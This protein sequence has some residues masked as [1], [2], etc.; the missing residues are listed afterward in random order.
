[1][2]PGCGQRAIGSWAWNLSARWPPDARKAGHL[3]PGQA[4]VR[5]P[6][7]GV[8]PVD[9]EAESNYELEN[10]KAGRGGEG[11]R[12]IPRRLLGLLILRGSSDL[13]RAPASYRGF[14]GRPRSSSTMAPRGGPPRGAGRSNPLFLSSKR[15]HHHPH[16]TQKTLARAWARIITVPQSDRRKR[17]DQRFQASGVDRLHANRGERGLLVKRS[18]PDSRLERASRGQR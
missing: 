1:M 2:P 15:G 10:E 18:S 4:L 11:Q 8:G 16:T 9:G 3:Q 5:D 14:G 6:F 17:F 7:Y 12:M 13:G